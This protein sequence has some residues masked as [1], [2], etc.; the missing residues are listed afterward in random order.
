MANIL[1]ATA[2]NWKGTAV[3]CDF[4][5]TAGGMSLAATGDPSVFQI[6]DGTVEVKLTATP[7]APTFWEATVSLAISSN[8]AISSAPA[9][10]AFVAV[11]PPTSSNPRATVATVHVNRF[12]DVTPEIFK[13]LKTPPTE[14]LG[15]PYDQAGI[16][17]SIYGAWP[18]A[19]WDLERLTDALFLDAQNPEKPGALNFIMDPLYGIIADNVVLKL[20]GVNAPQLFAVAW[21]A[22]VRRK[23]NAAPTPL[24]LFIRQGSGQNVAAGFFK[25]G[26]LGPYPN[27]FDYADVCLF[28]NLHYGKPP[29]ESWGPKGVPYQVAK[30]GVNAVTV[31]P[32]NSVGPE[33]GVLGDTEETGRILDELQAF[34][35]WKAGVASPPATIGK[36]AIGAF[37]SGNLFLNKWLKNPAN[38]KGNFLSSVVTAI[39]FLDPPKNAVVDCV[40]SALK[41]AGGPERDKRVRLYT[42]SPS[43]NAHQKLL[44]SKPPREPYVRNSPDNRH[45][46][47]VVSVSSWKKTFPNFA[48]DWDYSH[49]AIAATM[50]THALAQGDI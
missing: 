8:G 50:L 43:S 1:I 18:P 41:W 44:G 7:R 36:T 10:K 11:T 31:I 12:R 46:A 26:Q 49:H 22:I 23:A 45:T 19:D 42:T 47:S 27:N 4:A 34:M 25:G 30:A 9:S 20:A 13:L 32:C 29:L 48:V 5:A 14:R 40:T 16:D 39:Y 3:P 6:P 33:F 28:G 21:P 37:S 17:S 15:E 35:F 38:R 2:S 24:F